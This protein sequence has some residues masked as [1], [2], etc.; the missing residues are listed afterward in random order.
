MKTCTKCLKTMPESAF[1]GYSDPTRPLR[2]RCRVCLL[3]NH[4]KKSQPDWTPE[5]WD[6]YWEK[7]RSKRNRDEEKRYWRNSH[8]QKHYGITVEDQD[9]L[10]AEQDGRCAICRRVLAKDHICIDHDHES[11]VVRGA[12]CHS[13]NLSIGRMDEDVDRLTAAA[14]Y[15]WEHRWPQDRDE[16]DL[17]ETNRIEDLALIHTFLGA[18]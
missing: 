1:R 3:D 5:Q 15:L 12:L 18:Q 17:R 14:D 4:R 16:R 6:I 10:V 9:R 11:G 13:C 2:A 8:L 7:R